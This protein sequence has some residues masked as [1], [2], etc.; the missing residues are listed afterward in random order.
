[1]LSSAQRPDGRISTR[2]TMNIAIERLGYRAW[3]LL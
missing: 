3:N 2:E 1:M